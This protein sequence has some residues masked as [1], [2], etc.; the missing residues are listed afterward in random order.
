[1]AFPAINKNNIMKEQQAKNKT[2]DLSELTSL[3]T[4]IDFISSNISLP[5]NVANN[6]KNWSNTKHWLKNP[7]IVPEEKKNTYNITYSNTFSMND[8]DLLKLGLYSR[9]GDR[10]PSKK[11]RNLL[12][13]W[14]SEQLIQILLKDNPQVKNIRLSGVD[15]QRILQLSRT[16]TDPD[17]E[18]ILKNGKTIFVEVGCIGKETN[19]RKIRLK[20]NKVLQNEKRFFSLKSQWENYYLKP[21]IYISIDMISKNEKAYIIEGVDFYGKKF[22]YQFG[23]WEN[24][25]VLEYD[26]VNNRVNL[27]QLKTLNLVNF[28]KEV[29]QE[30]LHRHPSMKIFT[31]KYGN[32]QI[33][34]EETTRN[35]LKKFATKALSISQK[36]EE[37][38]KR[39]ILERNELEN[40]I[41]DLELHNIDDTTKK[42]INILKL[43]SNLA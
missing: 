30:I 37:S 23:G 22:P 39:K 12:L 35:K 15:A 18:I 36:L 25:L 2:H 32:I 16:P 43:Y 33:L 4:V 3:T 42:I 24:Q 1:M 9:R 31:E 40:K 41:R 21:T 38:R 19:D 14:L 20:Y 17:I 26:I 7:D 6:L 28:E 8:E 29:S 10:S 34:K 11:V 13:G 27:E 5:K